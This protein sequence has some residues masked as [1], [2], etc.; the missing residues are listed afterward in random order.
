[1]NTEAARTFV[2]RLAARAR[3]LDRR[4]LLAAGALVLVGLVL[5]LA[6]GRGNGWHHVTATVRRGDVR[7]VVQA[8]GT[9]NAVVT[10]QV[11]SEV[12]GRIAKLYADF[13]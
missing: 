13:N 4:V 8:T 11:G 1:M 5:V 3:A 10:V 9:L 12:S 2:S 7:D 6:R